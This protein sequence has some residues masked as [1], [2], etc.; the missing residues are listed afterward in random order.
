MRFDRLALTRDDLESMVTTLAAAV[1]AGLMTT[2]EARVYLG[3]GPMPVPAEPAP[4]P[5]EDP[6]PDPADDAG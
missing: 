6:E 3:L 4:E 2:D 5:D 1:G